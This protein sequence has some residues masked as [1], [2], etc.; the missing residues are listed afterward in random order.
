MN[1]EQLQYICAVYE[2]GSINRAAKRLYLSQPNLSNAIR[3]LEHELG[4]NIMIRSTAGVTF[5][6][7]GLTLVRRAKRVLEEYAS[8]QQMSG[9]TH[10]PRF[11]VLTPNYP[12]VEK[13]FTE[14]CGQ[15][16]RQGQLSG[17]YLRLSRAVWTESIRILGAKQAD[18]AIAAL[19]DNTAGSTDFQ[20][21]LRENGL[22][23][24]RLALSHSYVKLA[25][26]HPLLQEFP[27]PFE[28]LCEYPLTYY[29]HD[30]LDAPWN[31][32][33][34]LPFTVTPYKIYIDSGSTRTQIIANTN[35]WGISVKMRQ[36]DL[37]REGVCVVEIPDCRTV[38]GC[39]LRENRQE[40]PLEAPYLELLR[41]ELAFLDLE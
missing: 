41:R 37:D 39:L 16:S 2:T 26:G 25:K 31:G 14:L 40:N 35:A 38:I 5:T 13:A 21:K 24:Q 11:W 17:Y 34:Y 32:M 8:I 27:F 36:E 30:N 10:I 29:S 22:V 4:F 3:K 28:K 9:K 7:Q 6:E 20:K 1:L 12:P 15:L 23:F 18:L 19:P 33:K